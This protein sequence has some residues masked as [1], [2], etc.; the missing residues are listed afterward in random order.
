MAAVVIFILLVL[1]ACGGLYAFKGISAAF[2]GTPTP[3]PTS[4]PE[5]SSWYACTQFIQQKLGLSALDAQD[6]NAGGVVALK[7]SQYQVDVFY[8]KQATF[9]RCV[10]L[11]T[12]DGNWQLVSLALK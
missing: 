5:V 6:Y 8:A 10:I 4:R 3:E 1:L 2:S 11:H 9:Y 7:S 12:S